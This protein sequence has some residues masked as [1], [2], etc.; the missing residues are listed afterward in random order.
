MHLHLESF[1]SCLPSLGQGEPSL[2]RTVMKE[3]INY[4]RDRPPLLSNFMD[5]CKLPQSYVKKFREG[6]SEVERQ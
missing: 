2:Q 3:T 4:T 1:R 6:N 5:L